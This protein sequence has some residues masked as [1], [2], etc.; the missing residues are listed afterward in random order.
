MTG[1][2]L[3]DNCTLQRVSRITSYGRLILAFILFQIAT[4]TKEEQVS[5][6][7]WRHKH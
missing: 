5:L 1:Y 3:G 2:W 6:E 4:V 7:D